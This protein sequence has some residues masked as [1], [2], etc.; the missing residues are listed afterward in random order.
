MASRQSS[1]K[2]F[3]REDTPRSGSDQSTAKKRKSPE[4][5][6]R[7]ALKVLKLRSS[8]SP[9]RPAVRKKDLITLRSLEKAIRNQ[10]VDGRRSASKTATFSEAGE[11]QDQVDS[12]E[13]GDDDSEEGKP[14]Q[15]GF[16]GV[17]G[18]GV[19]SYR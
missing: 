5:A 4:S 8:A 6:L 9:T 19:D 15:R 10:S 11:M 12:V 16:G 18:V 17:R 13:Y 2:N 14:Q 7:Y 1:S 3:E